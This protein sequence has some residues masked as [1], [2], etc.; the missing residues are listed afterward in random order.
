[1]PFMSKPSVN[2]WA[3]FCEIPLTVKSSLEFSQPLLSK[4]SSVFVLGIPS[5]LLTSLSTLS[6]PAVGTLD[7]RGVLG[8]PGELK[9]HTLD[10]SE[11][12][13]DL[14]RKA[15]G[16]FFF[17]FWKSALFNLGVFSSISVLKSSSGSSKLSGGTC[18]KS[19]VNYLRKVSPHMTDQQSM[20]ILIKHL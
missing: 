9:L 16:Y 19:K 17:N 12:A 15:R 2:G 8:V 10:V 6:W 5:V 13:L 20:Q 1:M 7:L 11:K 18:K 3:E 4:V 14:R